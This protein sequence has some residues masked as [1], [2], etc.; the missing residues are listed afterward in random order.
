MPTIVETLKAKGTC[1]TRE[2][3]S[4]QVPELIFGCTMHL[5]RG[6]QGYVEQRQR[7]N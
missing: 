4:L 7:S 1:Y 6:V 3:P 2:V 5:P